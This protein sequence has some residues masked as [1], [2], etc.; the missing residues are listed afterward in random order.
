MI[1]KSFFLSCIGLCL[2]VLNLQAQVGFEKKKIKVQ[3]FIDGKLHPINQTLTRADK[4]IQFK[5]FDAQ[6]NK[7][8]AITLIDA[9]LIRNGQKII[10]I[11]LPGSGSIAKLVTKAHN[12]DKYVF[13]IRQLL[14]M[15]DDLSLKPFSDRT[16]KVSYGFFDAEIDEVKTTVGAN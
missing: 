4:D 3:M 14:E 2:M 12:N 9:T 10:S 5:A 6:S 8:L 1:I 7:E 15:A 13:E 16:F 11:T